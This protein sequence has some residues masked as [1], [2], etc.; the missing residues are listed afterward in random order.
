[1]AAS[2]TQ[3]PNK[4][5]RYSKRMYDRLFR[6]RRYTRETVQKDREYG[7][8]WYDWLWQILRKLLIFLCALL[9]IVGIAAGIWQRLYNGLISPPDKNDART[10]SFTVSSG[11]SVTTIGRH[12]TE[13]GFIRSASMFKYYVQFYGL[14]NKLQSGVYTLSKG[15]DL[16]ETADM[17]ASGKGTNERTIRIIPGWNVENIADYL[18]E[19][20]ALTDREEFL[21][22]CRE[23]QDYK[24]YSLAL[25]NADETADLSARI[26]PL[27]GYLAADTYRVYLSADAASIAHTLVKQMDTV[28]SS[29][30]TDANGER[31]TG[32]ACD[33]LLVLDAE[34]GA[35]RAL[36]DDELFILASIIEKEASSYEDM[37]RVSAVFYNRLSA[38]MRLQS[39][40]TATYLTGITRIALTT[41]DISVDTPYN[42]YRVYGLPVGPI[43]SP[44]RNALLAAQ[45]PD[46]EYLEQNYLY[47]CAAEPES[48]RLVFARTGEE[49]ARNVQTY[50]ALWEEY[51]REH[52]QKKG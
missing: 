22:E 20:G 9:V 12:L 50:R 1:M 31:K 39:D 15:M 41:Q 23:Y 28:Y 7:L 4:D 14:T 38:G 18:V 8:F 49:H 44:G 32:L 13:Q 26:Y 24:G 5:Q 47:F 19:A 6:T 21:A 51:D 3:K 36:T 11:E 42:T 30:F 2:K 43:C 25:I 52:A 48:G 34:D 29:L 27:E 33:S 17:L 46:S 45:N 35:K 37:R 16:F 10:Y 40:P